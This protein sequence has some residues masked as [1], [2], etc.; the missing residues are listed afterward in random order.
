MDSALT[1]EL[2]V[3]IL[4][5]MQWLMRIAN[6]VSDIGSSLLRFVQSPRRN[7]ATSES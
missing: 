4:R 7:C 2:T 6:I 1:C 3:V 5:Y